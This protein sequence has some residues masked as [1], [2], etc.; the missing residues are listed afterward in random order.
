MSGVELVR[1]LAGIGRLPPT[2]IISG[3]ASISETVEALRIGVHDF[4]EKPFT[5]ERLLQSIRNALEREALRR[6]VASLKADLGGEP[7]I[8]GSS[9]ALEELRTRVVLLSGGEPLLNREWR[10]I[11]ALLKN[12]GLALWLLT[13]GLSLAKHSEQAAELFDSVTVSL[14]GTCAG[15]GAILA[16]ASD[17]R[18]G[19]PRCQIAF[20]F[21][22]VGLAGCDMGACAL[23]PRIIGHGRASELLYTGR[24]MDASEA[25]AAGFLGRVVEPEALAAAAAELAAAIAR[26]P[27]FAHAMTKRM[28][29]QEWSMDLSSAIGGEAQAQALCMLTGDFRRAYE[30]FQRKATPAFENA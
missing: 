28:L 10:E 19:T 30:A 29:H 12:R 21:T 27:T 16:M 14:D 23:L 18:I 8:L 22:R 11:A 6:E 15:A 2:I 20:L 5:R 17:L 7:E 1:R 13:S 26:G 25:L 9:P 24:P 3:E 4:I